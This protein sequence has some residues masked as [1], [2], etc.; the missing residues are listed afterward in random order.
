MGSRTVR[1]TTHPQGIPRK[2][3]D[4]ARLPGF[5]WLPRAPRYHER[6]HCRKLLL[7]CPWALLIAQTPPPQAKTP[8]APP[9]TVAPAEKAPE[10]PSVPP[11]KVVIS[12]GDVKITAAEFNQIIDS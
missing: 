5:E 11:D 3:F 6:M 9:P 10:F 8:V 12:V 2:L 4:S 7:L 1:M